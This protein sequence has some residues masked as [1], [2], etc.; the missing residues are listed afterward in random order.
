[1]FPVETE[2]VPA[3]TLASL[4]LTR[5]PWQSLGKSG[6]R[7]WGAFRARRARRTRAEGSSVSDEGSNDPDESGA[8]SSRKASLYD[9]VPGVPDIELGRTLPTG[10]A[11][12]APWSAAE[13][14]SNPVQSRLES[15]K[16][17]SDASNH[18]S[19]S[20]MPNTPSSLPRLDKAPSQSPAPE[21]PA[22]ASTP[23]SGTG[24][25]LTFG[26]TRKDFGGG[27]AP[28]LSP[29]EKAKRNILTHTL[30]MPLTVSPLPPSAAGLP[31]SQRRATQQGSTQ[32]QAPA[33]WT[34]MH[35]VGSGA[36]PEPTSSSTP[37]STSRPAAARRTEPMQF[38]QLDLTPPTERADR[39]ERF[40]RN[41]PSERF[42]RAE[43]VTASRS[44]AP[45]SQPTLQDQPSAWQRPSQQPQRELPRWSERPRHPEYERETLPGSAPVR[46]PALSTREWL[47][48]GLLA[49]A[50]AATLYSL[51]IDDV[52]TPVEEDA[53]AATAAV[54][55]HVV[56][57]AP[58][59]E[60]GKVD[61]KPGAQ[62]AAAPAAASANL[63]EIVSEPARAEIVVG[64]AVIGNTPAQV[65]R[66]DKDADYLLRKQ[67]YE[68][69]LVRVT[70][71]SPKSI[72]IT[73]HPK[74]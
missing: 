71:H 56:K 67:G 61:S 22:R 65:P 63:T 35:R 48:I 39:S 16:A 18:S 14:A 64:G 69:Q 2:T 19:A 1:M 9:T 70:P 41:D 29:R 52:T 62:Q 57:P 17:S 6:G 46:V 55:E 23:P 53:E 74:Q 11:L 15:T 13:I 50:S 31:D 68:P 10:A 25:P 66:G 32:P 49:C 5:D 7:L 34:S 72:T 59:P 12:A 20:T 38:S 54:P 47:F 28:K 43:P 40:E 21:E 51:L 37:P 42:Q 33:G 58:L 44:E 27:S 36:P 60:P 24:G 3:K 30:Q 73:L 45:R 8:G 26:T 4:P